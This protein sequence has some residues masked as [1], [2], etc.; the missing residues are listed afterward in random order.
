M[1][2]LF[3]LVMELFYLV[4]ELFYLVM[5]PFL[6]SASEVR[7]SF[8]LWPCSFLHDGHAAP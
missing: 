6:F 8:T 5:E 3:Y 4:M 7:C 2:E 1:M